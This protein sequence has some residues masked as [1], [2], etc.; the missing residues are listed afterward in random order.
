MMSDVR[1]YC[2]RC[3]SLTGRSSRFCERCG[4]D[5]HRHSSAN[6]TVSFGKVVQAQRREPD[7]IVGVFNDHVLVRIIGEGGMGQVFE[8]MKCDSGQRFALKLVHEN[9]RLRGRAQMQA[10]MDEGKRQ[11]SI[12][13]PNVVR[14][15]G[16]MQDRHSGRMGLLLELID[17]DSLDVVLDAGGEGGFDVETVLLMSQHMTLGLQVVHQHGIVHADV[18][19]GNFMYGRGSSGKQSIKVS[20]FGI[21]RSLKAQLTGE[22][23]VLKARTPGYSSP[24][25]ILNTPLNVQS[26]LYCLGLVMY[27]LLTGQR[28]FALD[29]P[30]Q[31]DQDHLQTLPPYLGHALPEVPRRLAE[32]VAAL[33]NKDPLNRPSSAN[34]V[35]AELRMIQP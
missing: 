8:T 29:D 24:E 1:L 14:V 12:V 6:I 16:L 13:H 10:L 23:R 18:K 2:G 28:V 11:A 20:D 32:L 35:L 17:G 26:D 21:S 7:K 15:F 22:G 27:E 33:L 4:M 34:D 30:A 25:Q 5:L 31:C 19:P 9:F 3:R